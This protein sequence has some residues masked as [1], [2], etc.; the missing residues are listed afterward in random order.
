MKN[1]PLFWIFFS[2]L[3]YPLNVAFGVLVV[4]ANSP[5]LDFLGIHFPKPSLPVAD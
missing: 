5:R 1:P 4:L 3:L 2:P